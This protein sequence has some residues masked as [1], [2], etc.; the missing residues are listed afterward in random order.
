M[1]ICVSVS[2]FAHV[3]KGARGC[4][5]RESAPLELGSQTVVGADVEAGV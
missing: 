2:I 4:P 3:Y 1:T 5:E